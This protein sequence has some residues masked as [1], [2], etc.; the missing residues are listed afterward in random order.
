MSTRDGST[1][2]YEGKSSKHQDQCGVGLRAT[3]AAARKTNSVSLSLSLPPSLP[4]SQSPVFPFC[5][6]SNKC[7][8]CFSNGTR[9]NEETQVKGI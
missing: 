5:L 3:S 8:F 7:E 1:V 4:L 6:K 9:P 2:L